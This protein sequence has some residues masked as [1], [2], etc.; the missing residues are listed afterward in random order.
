MP[1][2]RRARMHALALAPALALAWPIGPA[3]AQND[4]GRPVSLAT[5]PITIDSLGLTLSLPEGSGA[6]TVASGTDATAVTTRVVFPDASGVTAIHGKRTKDNDLTVSA[7][8][9]D[10]RDQ[11]LATAGRINAAGELIP[12]SSR[13]RVLGTAQLTINEHEAS[14][15]YVEIP[16]TNAE[17]EIRGY[18]VFRPEPGRFVLFELFT[19]SDQ[20]DAARVAYETMVSTARFADAGELDLKRAA[21]IKAGAEAIASLTADDYREIFG[22]FGQRWE[23]LSRPGR[24][25]DEADAEEFGYRRVRAWIGRR[26][27]LEPDKPEDKWTDAEREPGYLLR[28]DARLLENG[29]T[30]D[31]RGIYFLSIDKDREIWSLRMALRR[32]GAKPSEWR[33]TG[34]RDKQSMVVRVEQDGASPRVIRPLMQ[35]EGYISM[36]EAQVLPQLLIRAGVPADF[37]FY[38]YQSQAETISLRTDSL[39]MPLGPDGQIEIITQPREGGPNQTAVYAPDGSLI[40]VERPDGRVWEPTEHRR[41]MSLWRSKGLPLD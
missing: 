32:E 19:T 39:R 31:S 7:V 24:S 1:H 22:S 41:L 25:G 15:V 34:I 18:T 5:A 2:R 23:R 13:A 12:G 14:R 36:V 33:E 26:G 9:D 29:M 17:G 37:A 27:E 40:R 38:A 28:V 30:V 20:F 3:Q 11:I 21:K 35:G 4:A 16:R 6:E 10:L 8:A